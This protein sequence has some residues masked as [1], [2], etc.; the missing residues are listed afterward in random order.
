MRL[1]LSENARNTPLLSPTGGLFRPQSYPE[2]GVPVSF[3]I[4][5][6]VD[7]TPKLT[8]SAKRPVLPCIGR[9]P[10]DV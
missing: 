3:N 5:P 10:L 4:E 1:L 2:L 9:A 6:A 8:N 7:S